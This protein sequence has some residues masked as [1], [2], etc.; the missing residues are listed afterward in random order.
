MWAAGP[1]IHFIG[2]D[3][4]RSHRETTTRLPHRRP[5]RDPMAQPLPARGIAAVAVVLHADSVDLSGKL[6][7]KPGQSVAVVNPPPGLVLPGVVATATAADADAVVAFVTR[8]KIWTRR[9]RRWRQ[10]AQ[11]A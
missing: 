10:R 4:S 1:R 11:T 9:S 8:Q 5:A 3:L 2:C 6:Q 7:I